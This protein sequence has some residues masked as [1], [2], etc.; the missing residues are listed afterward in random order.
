MPAP[1]TIGAAHRL[2]GVDR[3]ASPLDDR[4]DQVDVGQR[5]ARLGHVEGEGDDAVLLES[6][7]VVMRV[8]S[9][10]MAARFALH[11]LA[12]RI[13]RQLVDEIKAPRT[14]ECSDLLALAAEPVDAVFVQ[15]RVAAHN[16]GTDGTAPLVVGQADHGCLANAGAG[17]QYLLDLTRIDVLAAR[18]DH[19]VGAAL[20]I[21]VA[22]SVGP[23]QVAGVQPAVAQALARLGGVVPV[24]RPSSAGPARSAGRLRRVPP[25]RWEAHRDPGR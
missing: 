25:F 15:G 11:D 14:F 22:V 3:G 20:E 17:V 9:W 1:V 13:D 16:E 7:A 5:V 2:V 8:S 12:A 18:H 6:R 21:V 24:A 4:L 23:K 10:A 19:V